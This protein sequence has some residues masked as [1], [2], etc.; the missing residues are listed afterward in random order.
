M[1]P[2]AATADVTAPPL[3]RRHPTAM[4]VLGVVV[5]AAALRFAVVLFSKGGFS[6]NVGYDQSVYYSAADALTYGRMPYRDF[7]L[8]H[9]PALML[10]LTPFAALGR[11][12]TDHGGFVA[13]NIAFTLIGSANAGLIV[14]VARRFGYALRSA[15]IG[16]VFY[17]FWY[18]AVASEYSA[19]LEPLGTLAFLLGLLCL[20]GIREQRLRWT[21]A[22]GAAL[23]VALAVKIWWAVPV[24]AVLGWVL[25]ARPGRRQ[26]T[27]MITALI[28]APAAICLPFFLAAPGPMWRMVIT[29]QLGRHAA[30]VP[31]RR[32]DELASLHAALPNLAT[33]LVAVALALLGALVIW[34]CVVAWQAP[35]G[36]LIVCL[37]VVQIIV[38][39]ASPTY[40]DYYAG[41]PA[42]ALSLAVAAAAQPSTRRSLPRLRVAAPYLAAAVSG[43]LTLGALARQPGPT[44]FPGARLASSVSS[45]RCVMADDPMALISMDI[46][47]RDLARGCPDWVDVTG[48]TYDVDSPIDLKHPGRVENVRWQRDVS[49]YLRSGG[50]FILIRSAT[51][52]S[53]HTRARLD[54]YPAAVKVGGY[55]VRL[56]HHPIKQGG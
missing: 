25:L 1:E 17:A 19:R 5:L 45:V 38:L 11:I 50:A 31:W 36:R 12:T 40:F 15:V 33:P 44:S 55:T 35:G 49:R 3:W 34:V 27:A 10:A 56:V 54:R 29:D 23:G 26:A 42:G 16:G 13:A 8:L 37:L 7:I 47:S 32:L 28:A 9:P 51:G 6:G 4:A 41:Y 24:L 53:T 21:V 48:R 43:L 14:A 30:T 46:L 22:G 52:L 39:M 20:V 2:I 18:G